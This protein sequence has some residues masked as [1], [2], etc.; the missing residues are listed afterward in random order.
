MINFPIKCMKWSKMSHSVSDLT[1]RALGVA[2]TTM[3]RAAM[4][5]TTGHVNLTPRLN[6][7]HPGV[8]SVHFSTKCELNKFTVVRKEW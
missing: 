5:I 6:N 7:L 4:L 1:D 3:H 2:R 8:P